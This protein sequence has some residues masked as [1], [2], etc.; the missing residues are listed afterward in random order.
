MNWL[1]YFLIAMAVLVFFLL[2]AV[3]AGAMKYKDR[4]LTPFRLVCVGVFLSVFL[5]LLPIH[6]D[7]FRDTS[8]STL[9]AVLF[10]LQSTFRIFTVDS[11]RSILD[12]IT[13]PEPWLAAA[14]SAFLSIAHV[15]APILTFGF[16]ASLFKNLSATLRYRCAFF[17]DV[18]VFSELNE[19]SLFLATDI[20]K[21]HKSARIVFTNVSETSDETQSA[22]VEQVRGL[23]GI[24]FR[25]SI[26]SVNFQHHAPLA[27]ITFFAIGTDETQNLNESLQLIKRYGQRDKTRLY[28]FTTRIDGE[29]L[30]AN[31]EKGPMKVRRVNEVRSLID[32]I[33]YERGNVLFEDA[34]TAPDGERYISAV[35]IGLG[36]HGTEML[37][38]LAWYCQMDGYHITVDAFDADERAEDRFAATAPELMSAAYNG[39]SIPGEAEYTIRIHSGVDVTTKTFADAIARL[40]DTTYVFVS[41]GADE[42]SIRAAVEL[43]RLFARKRIR[44]TIQAVITSPDERD[45]LNGITNFRGQPYA[46]DFIGDAR[47][48]YCEKVILNSELEAEALARHLKWG[49]ESEFWQYEYNYNSSVA[50]ALHR[51]ARIAC[52]IPGAEKSEDALTDEERIGIEI[53]EHRRW[54]AY[55]RSEGYVYSGST[56][57]SSR[58]DLA[59]MHH[60][61]VDYAALSEAEK[62]KDSCV[63]T[64]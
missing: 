18:Y 24:C 59:K 47:T 26:L 44:P 22:A 20:R 21:H 41:L 43:R 27:A 11:E 35:L 13:C 48:S 58:N 5:C 34:K 29:L 40:P 10:S 16:L 52:H 23:H 1:V 42:R 15:V 62:R 19:K 45:A 8:N 61:L 56:D 51:R 31:A 53:L 46:I 63:G 6:L 14:Y 55:M 64:I 37:K 4:V 49:Q 3:A 32:R 33:L 39:V 57:P 9:K 60:D 17:N 50:S 2:R 30:L 54:N 25:K 36:Q 12:G 7:I 28:V 38:A